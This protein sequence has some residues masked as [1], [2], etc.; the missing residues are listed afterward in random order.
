VSS[1]PGSACFFSKYSQ[2]TFLYDNRGF[3]ENLARELLSIGRNIGHRS[4]LI[5]TTDEGAVFAAEY[6][7][8]LKEHFTFPNQSVELVRSLCSKKDMYY[9]AQKFKIPTPEAV[10][11]QSRDD[12]SNFLEIASFPIMLKAIHG[13]R[14]LKRSGTSGIIVRTKRD[15]FEKYDAMEDPDEPNLMLQEYI[16]GGDDSVWMFNGYFS[17]RSDCIVGFTGKKIRQWPIHRGVTSLGVCLKN[18][19]VAKTSREFMQALGYKGIV[20]MGYRYDGRDGQYKVLDI[21]PRI[22]ATFRLFVSDNGMDVARVLY[23]DMTGR[24]MTIGRVPEGR[25]WIVEDLDVE[26]SLL[27]LLDGSL[28]LKEWFS[29]YN[30]IRE[31][32]Y[33][34]SDDPVPFLQ[35]LVS[36]LGKASFLP[37]RS[38]WRS[39]H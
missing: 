11:P 26:S 39:N 3:K 20:D 5:P 16:P 33:F 12:V 23:H 13:W 31:S 6:A 35:M 29:S 17:E 36:N 18:E 30:G 27:C 2:R 10:F 7:D 22:G 19:T 4:L 32:A 34:T 38:L 25:K 24:P 8:I 9:L 21:N 15:L 1:N 28:H 37:I 14:L